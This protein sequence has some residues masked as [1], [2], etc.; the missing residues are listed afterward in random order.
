MNKK[1]YP[2]VDALCPGAIWIWYT[3]FPLRSFH[4]KQDSTIILGFFGEP[5]EN[6]PGPK[7]IKCDDWMRLHATLAVAG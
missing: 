1:L 7:L 3:T 4:I 6:S 2:A 5:I